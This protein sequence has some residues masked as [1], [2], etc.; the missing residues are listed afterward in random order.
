[1]LGAWSITVAFRFLGSQIQGW[2]YRRV[3]RKVQ[4]PFST[5]LSLVSPRGRGYSSCISRNGTGV[6]HRNQLRS[7]SKYPCLQNANENYMERYTCRKT[8]LGLGHS[9]LAGISMWQQQYF[10]A[11]ILFLEL[12]FTG[13]ID[14]VKFRSQK[15]MASVRLLRQERPVCAY[16]CQYH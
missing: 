8:F 14:W 15:G 12:F 5:C 3:Y 13:G 10:S 1:M 6:D 2:D 11:E 7:V 9:S 4:L 16:E